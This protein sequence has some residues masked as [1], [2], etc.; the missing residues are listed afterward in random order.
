VATIVV[1]NFLGVTS[2]A[3]R[4]TDHVGVELDLMPGRTEIPLD[5]EFEYAL[6]VLDGS[7]GVGGHTLDPSGLGYLG[8]GRAEVRMDAADPVRA[9]LIGGRPFPEPLLMWWNYVARTRD[10]ITE[11]HR[12]WVI[13]DDR[14]GRFASPL[15]RMSTGDPPWGDSAG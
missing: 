5:P 10:E 15:D 2:P 7:L 6:A 1:G 14:F 13:G 12:A 3:R 11:A 9:L 4:D 8:L